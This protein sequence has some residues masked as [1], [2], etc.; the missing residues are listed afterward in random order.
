MRFN[1]FLT[2]L[3]FCFCGV[4]PIESQ[5]RGFSVELIHP[6]SS[7]SPFYNSRET[8]LQRV[9]NVVT[10]SINRVHYL[11]H[12]LSFSHNDSPKTT[13]IPYAGSYY[14]MSY[15]IGT[16]PFHLY[17]VVDTGSDGIWF[18]CKPCKP[19]LN[20]T[21]LI[22]NPSKSSTYKNI[23]CLSPICKLGENTRCSSD[24]KKK[25]EYEVAY[26]D[27][28]ESQGDISKDTLTLNSNDGSPISFPRIVI[29]CGHHNS[30]ATEGR[31]SGI[32]GFGRGNFSLVSQLSSS[33]GGKFSYCL[34]PLFSKA[35]IS[36]KLYFGDMA[37]VSGH[38]VV[39]TPL[40]ETFYSGNYF[41]NLEA[42]SV[43]DH[44]IKFKHS[45]LIPDNE[46]NTIIDSGS[47]IT[48]LP[49]DVY[50]QL[51]TAVISMVKLK[52]VKDPTKQ[53]SLCYETTLKKYKVPIITAHF[54]GAD[55]KLNALNTFIQMNHEV[56]CFAFNSS[57]LPWVVYGNIAQQNFLVGYDTLQNII[58]FKPTNCTKL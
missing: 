34:A 2:L 58:S 1:L 46:G 36:S 13:I 31:A 26:M 45:S 29:G 25:C 16:P 21:S 4:T 10:H 41:T 53:L 20:Q 14:V 30:L 28:S 49:N 37:L 22:F 35:N 48:Q 8:Q 42:F 33:I 5:N 40:L 39:S 17:G 56:M 15:S 43:G 32:I 50:S 57:I 52:R 18:Q 6:D 55:V 7:R 44:I 38:G 23:R 12:V 11:N 51:E 27:R 9:S 54:R 3:F 47:T 19:C 24:R